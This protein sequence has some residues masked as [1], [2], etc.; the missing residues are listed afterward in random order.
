MIGIFAILIFVALGLKY[1]FITILK[2][3]GFIY[4]CYFIY[5]VYNSA[6]FIGVIKLLAIGVF[7]AILVAIYLKYSSLDN[8]EYRVIDK[9]C[10]LRYEIQQKFNSGNHY[11]TLEYLKKSLMKGENTELYHKLGYMYENGYGTEK[12]YSKAMK[13]YQKAN[14][15]R[16]IGYMHYFGYG[17]YKDRD[18]ANEY[19]AKCDDRKD[20]EEVIKCFEAIAHYDKNAI[21]HYNLGYFYDSGKGISQDY[22][23]AL[24]HYKKAADLGNSNACNNL[25]FMYQFGH[26][27]KKDCYTARDYYQKGAD[28]GNAMACNNL[29][30]CYEYGGGGLLLGLKT[31]KYKALKYYKKACDLGNQKGCENYKRLKAQMGITNDDEVL[32]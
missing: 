14:S 16:E 1:G 3:I 6:G 2:W 10:E 22:Q 26:G 21:A 28:L 7:I 27:I 25:G 24:Y 11:A 23:K 20:C 29:G 15:W 18:R 17:V 4:L 30:D 5:T 31:D 19:F 12:D 13:C 32:F 9:N 8:D